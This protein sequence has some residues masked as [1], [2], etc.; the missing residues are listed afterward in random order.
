M[1]KQFYISI[2]SLLTL[3]EILNAND[4]AAAPVYA[5]VAS[6]QDQLVTLDTINQGIV[7]T[8]QKATNVVGLNFDQQKNELVVQEDGAYFL[9][10]V[11]QMGAREQAD[12]IV[13]GGDIYFWIEVNGKAIEDSGSWIFAS[14]SARAH[15][16][17]DNLIQTFKAGD[18]IRFKFSANSPSMG[19]ITFEATE[20]W[21]ASPGLTV[22]VYK[23]N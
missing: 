2:F 16:I 15:T 9:M 5:Q 13:K 3:L 14:P 20:K 23:I 6:N 8:I 18:R 19:L 21:P 7:A 17:V 4:A 11:A 22:S 1:R 10:A 12:N